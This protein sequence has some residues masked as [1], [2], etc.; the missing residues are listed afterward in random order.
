[1]AHE[2]LGIKLR[3][4]DN[5]ISRLNSRIR[6]SETASN[7][8]LREEIQSLKQ[9]CRETKL[10]LKQKLRHSKAEDVA[11][12]R[13]A[14]EDVERIIKNT[15]DALIDRQKKKDPVSFSLTK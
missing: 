13:N 3:E 1:M 14:F 7:P 6:L 9:D 2:I 11:L 12:L 10:S 8:K 15:E 5:R 4:L